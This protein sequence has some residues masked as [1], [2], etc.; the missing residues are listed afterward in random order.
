MI[1]LTID[2]QKISLEPG[3]SV[4]EA[5]QQM[6]MKIPTLCHHRAL[7]AYGAC[8]LCLVEV[9]ERGRNRVQASC[10][11]PAREGLIVRTNTERVIKT[12]RIMAE[13]LLARCPNSEK[14]KAAAAE[15]G[16]TESRFP[17]KDEECILCGL[18]TR[19]C[20]ELMKT[21]AVDFA[22]RGNR[23]KVSPAY[24]KHSPICMACGACRVI[25]PTGAV[26]LDK[27]ST[28]EPRPILAEFDAGL[29]GRPSIY[30]PYQQAIPK[31][32]V[33]DRETCV[34]FRKG[35]EL[36][37]CR[38]CEKFC[39]AKAIDYS[40]QDGVLDLDV[41]AVII[42]PGFELCDHTL[43]AEYGF[44]QYPNVISS[45][46]FERVLSASGPYQGHVLRPYDSKE[47]KRIASIQCVGSRDDETPYCSSVCCMYA[48]KHALMAREHRRGS[49]TRSSSWTSAPTAR[50]STLTTSEPRTRGCGSCGR[51]RRLLR[52]PAR[53]GT[54][55]SSTS[56]SAAS[57]RTRSLISSFS[58][59]ACAPRAGPSRWPGGWAWSGRTTATVSRALWPRW[60]QTA[61]A[62]SSAGPSPSPKTFPRRSCRRAPPPHAP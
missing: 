31:V 44:G 20:W 29:V 49:N 57:S 55:A 41:G 3:K 10:L 53:S 50:A 15:L 32:P 23:R 42:A 8:R 47:P 4:L 21:G 37:A 27:I 52:R 60:T 22:G 58:P 39:E 1:S 56:T 28:H 61:Q 48:V 17:K 35:G 36:D 33:I 62:S 59:A 34:H 9:E 30:I 24:D 54:S 7:P 45:L 26:N 5:C 25:C 38:A 40:Q 43:R 51:A 46:Q 12:R 19:V 18:C 14:V 16:V 11:Y 6:G 13:L 2:G